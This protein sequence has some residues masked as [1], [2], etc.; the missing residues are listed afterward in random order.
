MSLWNWLTGHLS[1]F[2]ST[3]APYP[4]KVLHSVIMKDVAR[5]YFPDTEMV[6][7]DLWPLLSP[8]LWV[9]DAAA[10]LEVNRRLNVK[11]D[12][13]HGLFG[14]MT[15]GPSL[16]HTNGKEWNGEVFCD[17]LERK[18]KEKSV[19][20]LEVLSMRFSL[21][22]IM[23]LA[24][25][26]DFDHQCNPHPVPMSLI[27]II[28]WITVGNP[29]QELNPMRHYRIWEY[30]RI[31][32]KHMYPELEKRYTDY[33]ADPASNASN[34]LYTLTLT[35]HSKKHPDR[36][37]PGKKMDKYFLDNALYQIRMLLV[38]GHDTSSSVLVYAFHALQKNPETLKRLREEHTRVFGPDPSRAASMMRDKAALLNEIPYTVAVV[39][40]RDGSPNVSLADRNGTRYPTA[41]IY[42]AIAHH[43]VHYSP[44][45]YTDP[46]RFM[47]ERFLDGSTEK[48]ERGAWRPFEHGP[49]A[50]LGYN[51]A[52]MQMKIILVL[53]ARRFD[54]K[55][56]YEEWEA[57]EKGSRREESSEGRSLLLGLFG[58][59]RTD[60]TTKRD[61][62]GELA[63]QCE[64]GGARPNKAYPC[65]VEM[66]EE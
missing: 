35:G 36:A 32:N 19:L 15:G 38:A 65:R 48:I 47:T 26:L 17:M 34:S 2:I 23:K 54:I 42:V 49:R 4:S 9:G 43:T 6:Y 14:P 13:Y 22:S 53:C 56:A 45:T 66:H 5:R 40:S 58:G 24:L 51:V 46:E 20:P 55:L 39:P 7:L 44:H 61:V 28:P 41:G 12:V 57:L 62:D 33:M 8:V 31:I 52:L 50:C 10:A 27:S 60:K 37:G 11:P 59:K 29:F 21:E 25:D 18:A 3:V 64:N 63:Y 16:L 1:F 30:G